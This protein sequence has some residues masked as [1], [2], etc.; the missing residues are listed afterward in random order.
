VK[1]VVD[2]EDNFS[3]IMRKAS[4]GTQIAPPAIA[5]ATAIDPKRLEM[6]GDDKN[7]PTEDEARSV[8]RA[9]RLD[10]DKLVE[11]ACRDW[12]PQPQEQAER[13]GHQFNAP[14][15]SNGYFVIES[16]QR[17]AAIVDP[18]GAADNIVDVLRRSG[19][20]L[21]YILLTHKHH[22]HVDAVP[23]VRA[24][25]PQARVVVNKLDAPAIGD[26]ARDALSPNDGE[27]IPFGSGEIRF[28]H[29]PGHTDGSSC[30]IYR[31][32]IFTGDTMFAGSVGRSFDKRYGYDD[33]LENVR[34]KILTLPAETVVLPGH[35]P[36]STIAE[37]RA[38][39]PFF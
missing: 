27:T 34:T 29:T 4:S 7:P 5:R 17:I 25:F 23:E 9:L 1:I 24:A 22:D 12:K 8:A 3:D 37:E 35:G 39:N 38:H 13:I 33:L 31:G 28:V 26:L 11:I 21:A 10:P 20:E 14:Y 19:A 32:A 18:G 16:E 36:P 15:F 2:R 30:F 6:I